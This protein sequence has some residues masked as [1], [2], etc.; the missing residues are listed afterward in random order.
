MV[1]RRSTANALELVRDP[2]RLVVHM[3]RALIDLP[4]IVAA[5]K[6]VHSALGSLGGGAARPAIEKARQTLA[7]LRVIFVARYADTP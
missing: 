5:L 4:Q 7:V 3:H 6:T 2:R 1:R